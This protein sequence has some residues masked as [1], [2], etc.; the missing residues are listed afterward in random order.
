MDS[1]HDKGLQRALCYRYTTGHIVWQISEQDGSSKAKSARPRGERSPSAACDQNRRDGTLQMPGS[2]R[3]AAGRDGPRPEAPLELEPFEQLL[4][5][6]LV[7]GRAGAVFVVVDDRFAEARRLG[8]ARRA[9]NHRLEYRLAEMLP[10]FAHDLVG[11][12]GA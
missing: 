2:G 9:R 11:K 4:R 7:G 12:I 1:N 10:D 3:C 6:D 5:Q 8:Q